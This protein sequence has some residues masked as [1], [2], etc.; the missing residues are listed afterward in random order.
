M[1][2]VRAIYQ[3]HFWDISLGVWVLLF[4][5]I[6]LVPFYYLQPVVLSSHLPGF[7][8]LKYLPLCLISCQLL[9]FGV[10]AALKCIP[11]GRTDID[12]YLLFY[13]SVAAASLMG[14]EYLVIGSVKF[15][16]YALTGFVLGHLLVGFSFEPENLYRLVRWMVGIAGVVALYGITVYISG[17][18]FLWGEF[19]AENNPYYSGPRRVAASIGNAVFAG[20]YFAICLP[21]ALWAAESVKGSQRPLYVI[22]CLLILAA[23]LFTFARGSW[24]AAGLAAAIYLSPRLGK[25]VGR[26]R[27]SLSWVRIATA[28]VV[29]LLLSP[30]LEEAGFLNPGQQIL[31]DVQTR[32]KQSRELSESEAFRISQ[33]GTTWNILQDHP[34]L[35]I[36][37]GNFTRL[38]QKYRH[39]M[40]PKGFI[41]TTTENMYLM[42]ASETGFFGIGSFVCLLWAIV[43]TAFR[44]YKDSLPGRG[45][46][47]L[48]ASTGAIAGFSL[49][50][51]TWDALNQPTVRIVFWMFVGIALVQVGHSKIERETTKRDL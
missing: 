7:L 5:Y 36:G 30:I 44:G 21:Y 34:F 28:L 45:K 40:T 49:N 22:L 6:S 19:Y 1:L 38:F 42:V 3:R 41:A 17:D 25:I 50:M 31:Y 13:V 15:V 47:L 10:G 35:G 11:V 23:L 14:A 9:H 27:R 20:A 24:I 18:D 43:R 8:L 2:N 12:R 4:S 37:F 46:D 39:E 33:Y 29:G 48:L 26:I 16:Y 51:M 32:M